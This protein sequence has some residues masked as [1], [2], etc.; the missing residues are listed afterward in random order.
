[1]SKI[2]G[3]VVTRESNSGIPY[4]VVTAFDYHSKVLPE[5]LLKT[6]PPIYNFPLSQIDSRRIGSTI[7]DDN[8]N[9]EIDYI[10]PK[11]R[12]PFLKDFINQLIVLTGSEDK[13][14]RDFPCILHVSD[15]R[16]KAAPVENYLIKVS[17]V[18]ITETNKDKNRGVSPFMDSINLLREIQRSTDLKIK[19]KLKGERLVKH[20]QPS[21]KA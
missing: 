1:M 4:L 10:K 8:G 3:K 7:T 19:D 11:R 6:K 15:I 5:E 21:H 16:Y 9:L 20:P 13:L 17:D 2:K 12:L 14:A 18:V